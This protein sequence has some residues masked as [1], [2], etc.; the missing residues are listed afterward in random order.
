MVR[1]SGR[2]RWF[3]K[4]SSASSFQESS[5]AIPL[6]HA[7]AQESRSLGFRPQVTPLEGW[8]PLGIGPHMTLRDF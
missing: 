3:W 1:R 8:L 5:H 2:E 6:W 4:A 7:A